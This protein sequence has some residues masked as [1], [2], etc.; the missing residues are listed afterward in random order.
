MCVRRRIA[1]LRA[2]PLSFFI[3]IV[4]LVHLKNKI[5]DRAAPA[6]VDDISTAS[7]R[8]ELEGHANSRRIQT[9]ITAIVP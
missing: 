5:L 9:G 3:P 8:T 4:E 2:H 7:G 1:Y 6:L